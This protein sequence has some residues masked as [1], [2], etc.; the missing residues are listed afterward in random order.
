VTGLPTFFDLAVDRTRGLVY[1]SDPGSASVNGRVIALNSNTGAQVWQVSFGIN[2]WALGMDMSPDGSTLAVALLGLGEIALINLDTR[3]VVGYMVPQGVGGP[4]PNPYQTNSPFDVLYGRA[5]RLYSVGSALAGHD[6]VHV[7]DTTTDLEVGRST[8]NVADSPRLAISPD[9]NT[10]FV[11]ESGYTNQRLDKFDISTD[12]LPAPVQTYVTGD[13]LQLKPDGSEVYVDGGGISGTVFDA[14]LTHELGKFDLPYWGSTYWAGMSYAGGKVYLS[15]GG[16]PGNGP[17]QVAAVDVSA[18]PYKLVGLLP[19]SGS[20]TRGNAVNPSGT[21]LYV[22]T[23]TTFNIVDLT[24]PFPPAPAHPSVVPYSALVLDAT[25]GVLYGSD[26]GKGAVQVISATDGSVMS[27]I[28]LGVADV[29]AGMDISPDG[30]RLAVALSGTAQVAIIDLNLRTVVG[31]M[32]LPIAHSPPDVRY[33]RAGRLY[34]SDNNGG[35][36][37]VF[38]TSTDAEVGQSPLTQSGPTQL[39]ISPDHNSAYTI[40]PP[41]YAVSPAPLDKFDIT[42]D[43]PPAPVQATGNTD[44]GQL[45]VRSDG[46]QL[47]VSD[48]AAWSGNVGTRLGTLGSG[49][50]YEAYSST[51]DW[52][53][54]SHGSSVTAMSASSPYSAIHDRPFA[55]QVGPLQVNSAGTTIYVS[56]AF[57]VKVITWGTADPPPGVDAVHGNAQATVT[58]SAPAYVGTSPITG[59]TVKSSPGGLTKTVGSG[60]FST[61]MS[62]LVNGTAYTFTVTANNATGPSNPST[63]SNTVTPR[64]PTVPTAPTNVVAAAGIEKAT[65]SWTAPA[66]D[67][68]SAITGYTVTSSPGGITATTGPLAGSAVVSPLTPGTSYTFTVKAGNGIGPGASS[69]SSNAVTVLSPTAPGPP[70]NVTAVAGNGQV[71]V[72]WS[73]PASDGNRPIN[74]YTVTPSEGGVTASA[75]GSATSAIVSPLVNGTYYSFT[76]TATNSIGTSAPSA[77]SSYVTPFAPTVPQPPANVTAIPGNG[78][79]SVSWTAPW[80]GRSPIT[81]YTVTS[82]PG[83]VIATAGPSA[84][85]VAVSGLANGT[86]YIFT[87]VASNAVGPSAAS[88][89]SNA[90]TPG[91]PSAPLN[92]TATAGVG[93]ATVSWT[94]P[95]DPGIQPITSYRINSSGGASRIVPATATQAI[96]AGLTATPHTFTVTA[97]N[98]LGDGL[99]SASSSSI[100]PQPGGTYHA[101][102]TPQRLLDTRNGTGGVPVSRLASGHTINLQVTGHGGVPAGGVSAVIL[103]LT[104]TGATGGGFITAFPHGVT[105][106]TASSLNFVRGQTVANLV[107]VAVGSDGRVSLYA[108][109][110]STQVLADVEGWVGDASD[111][112]GR[113]GLFNPTPPHRIL[114]T[115]SGIGSPVARVGPGQTLNLQIS[116]LLSAVQISEISAVVLNVTVTNSTSPGFLTIYPGGATRPLASNLNFVGGQTVA[117]RVIVAVG[118]SGEI[119]IYNGAGSVDLIADISGWFTNSSSSQGGSAFAGVTP[120][121]FFDSRK[122]GSGGRLAPHDSRI[123]TINGLPT[124][125]L[126]INLTATRGSAAGYL[127]VWPQSGNGPDFVPPTSDLN[128]VGGQTVANMVVIGL[129]GTSTFYIYNGP[130]YVDVV[131][132]VD[133]Y[134]TQSVAA[135]P[136][137]AALMT[138]RLEGIGPRTPSTGP[139]GTTSA[140]TAP[141]IR[142][143]SR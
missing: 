61:T 105:R 65:V 140:G 55:S 47:Y 114:D 106:P 112:Y 136:L 101:L 123:F 44:V 7:F 50:P 125:G 48:G 98:S 104:V 58:W 130:A 73:P 69:A 10:L 81:G 29:P 67:G 13:N 68:D 108:G 59:Y 56:T 21:V 22:S 107:E 77:P 27:S 54:V 1:G 117:N 32:Y 39:A 124:S 75:G 70:T 109:G 12:T 64:V 92:V 31:H 133:G 35:N 74:A 87:V 83:G 135:P 63:P 8:S 34:T 49:G 25:R 115:R 4:G 3:S 46:S 71:T 19:L 116:G 18:F 79:A 80:D 40:T 137:T 28:D 129:I 9:H 88:A 20:Q 42:T 93:A 57:G 33:G 90:V 45:A 78:Q 138:P 103:N 139:G 119:S 84:T 43:S 72:S 60:T 100:D 76:V 38:D 89:P 52:L 120:S 91:T 94:V 142:L 141:V 2:S 53:F 96:I 127:T 95:V 14:T 131:A 24:L 17:A 5:G 26:Q 23:D 126:V 122:A 118:S 62:P 111:S 121:R 85:S 86:T 41:Y 110:A 99:A 128:F 11:K 15:E 97:I 66:D 102:T 132:D 134:Y 6:Y 30:S 36:L 16:G 113:D 143:R 82:S 37:H 51:R